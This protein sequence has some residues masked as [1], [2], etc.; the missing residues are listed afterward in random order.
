QPQPVSKIREQGIHPPVRREVSERRWPSRAVESSA[1]PVGAWN[2]PKPPHTRM[3]LIPLSIRL[4]SSDPDKRLA[5]VKEAAASG[6]GADGWMAA[7]AEAGLH[8]RAWAMKTLV[9][10]GDERVV[11]TIAA[12]LGERA[13]GGQA[14]NAQLARGSREPR[15]ND[16]GAMLVRLRGPKSMDAL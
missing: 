15:L 13:R 7:L 9:G 2:N 10:R 12:Q 4:K 6:D 5:A 11:D 1:W 3:A 8:I 14:A 16:L